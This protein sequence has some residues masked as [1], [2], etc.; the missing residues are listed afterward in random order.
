MTLVGDVAQT[1][2][3]VGCLVLAQVLRPYVAKRWRGPRELTVNYRTPAEIMLGWPRC[4]PRWT[5]RWRP[6]PRCARPAR[7]RARHG[8][9]PATRAHRL[10]PGGRANSARPPRR[11]RAGR[12][13]RDWSGTA[14]DPRRGPELTSAV[15]V[16]TVRQAKGLEFDEVVLVDPA[17]IVAESPRGRSDL[18]V[19]LT[20]ATQR[21]TILYEGELPPPL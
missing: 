1:G 6:A 4:W 10:R 7:S 2:E 20:R 8:C 18:Y 19:A 14:A 17:D 11:A 15:V 16:L 21:L 12:A 9:G 5:P 13:G 3:L